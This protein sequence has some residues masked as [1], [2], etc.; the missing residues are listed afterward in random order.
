MSRLRSLLISWHH[1]FMM[2]RV[3]DLFIPFQCSFVP[4]VGFGNGRF[5]SSDWPA[6][7]REWDVIFD[8]F[9]RL[10]TKNRANTIKICC[11]F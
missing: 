9:L 10:Y 1:Y 2:D 11:G 7:K 3:Q 6:N 8:S 5:A 4:E